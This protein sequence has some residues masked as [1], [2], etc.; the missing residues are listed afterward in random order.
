MGLEYHEIFPMERADVER[1]LNS[2]NQ[3]AIIDAL[4]GA[5]FYDAD[6]RWVQ[7]TCLRFLDHQKNGSVGTLQLA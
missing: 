5:A 3:Q 1:L 4:L 6:W 7:A 2:G